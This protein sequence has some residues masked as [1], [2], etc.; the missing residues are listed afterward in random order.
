M[1][2]PERREDTMLLSSPGV[3][4]QHTRGRR[5]RQLLEHALRRVACRRRFQDGCMACDSLA[6]L[7][8]PSAL[9][10]RRCSELST[11]S[12]ATAELA[13]RAL[14][15]GP[16]KTSHPHVPRARDCAPTCGAGCVHASMNF[17]CSCGAKVFGA[18]R[19]REEGGGT[20][21]GH[22]VQQLARGL[23][24]IA[25]IVEAGVSMSSRARCQRRHCEAQ[26]CGWAG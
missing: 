5:P 14:R 12:V 9:G 3:S 2:L 23:V 17:L 18:E 16:G 4:P 25:S 26:G 6:Q 24:L 20:K 13:T 7:V 22:K 11:L 21:E 1:V 8:S 19:S 15:A 10:Q